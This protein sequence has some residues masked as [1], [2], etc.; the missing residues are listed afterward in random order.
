MRS[1][2]P[3]A[4]QRHRRNLNRRRAPLVESLEIRQ[5]LTAELVTAIGPILAHP[6]NPSQDTFDLSLHLADSAGTG[7]IAHFHTNMGDF[8]I[9][10][11]DAATPI[12]VAN[13]LHYITNGEFNRT[14]FSRSVPGFVEQLGGYN[15]NRLHQHIPVAAP[16]PSEFNS[17]NPVHN[18][19]GTVAMALSGSSNNT[20]QSEWFVSLADNSANLDKQNGGFTVFGS[21]VGDG[22]TVIDK[23]A[24]Q[25]V[26]DISKVTHNS[27]LTTV[28]LRGYPTGSPKPAPPI[29]FRNLIEV[30]SATAQ[31]GMTYTATSD[32]PHLVQPIISGR[33]ISFSYA[34]GA[35]GV[36]NVTV[37]G[38]SFDGTTVSTTFAVTVPTSSG[39]LVANLDTPGNVFLN[40]A[41][42][43]HPLS[44]DTDTS[45]AINPA[46][47]AIA[48]QPAH[49][50][51]TVDA[52]TGTINYTPTSGF[53]G[54][55]SF[56]Y[57]V[58]DLTGATS[59]AATVSFTVVAPP[60]HVTIGTAGAGSLTWTEPDGTVAHLSVT[61]GTA[62]VAFASASVTTTK[63]GGVVTATG[64][65]ATVSSITIT[66]AR[67]HAATLTITASGGADGLASIGTITDTG[68]VAAV[69]AAGANLTGSLTV[70]SLASLTLGATN[71]ALITIGGT[72]S[73]AV[74]IGNAIDTSIVAPQAR[75]TTVRAKE[76]LDTDGLADRIDAVSI[77]SLIINGPSAAR[78]DLASAG[79]SLGSATIGGALTTGQW[80]LAGSAGSITAKSA[81]AGWLL[82]SAGPVA[83]LR[84]NGDFAG[85]IAAHSSVANV[86]IRGNATGQFLAGSFGTVMITGDLTGNV[87]TNG[88]FNAKSLQLGRL[89][90][91]GNILN[92]QIVASGNIGSVTAKRL[93]GASIY[94]GVI[95]TVSQGSN[96]PATQADLTAA[97]SIGS[98][99]LAS[100]TDAVPA[101]S[102]ARIAAQTLGPLALGF[103]QDSIGGLVEGV[104]GLTLKALSGTLSATDK[105]LA[106][107]AKTLRDQATVNTFIADNHITLNDFKIV[108]VP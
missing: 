94:A 66:N 57:T 18:V 55:D 105:R 61:G 12:T 87:T 71:R 27:A 32:N 97:A 52:S 86:S 98:V 99:R 106:L 36:A 34:T 42:Q 8:D 101:F 51:A 60:V 93:A 13:F 77:G 89:S 11:T 9:A 21:V 30:I 48:T 41:A 108:I 15:I 3:R 53:T 25:A 84:V 95:S 103:I 54:P 73:L 90:V 58:R 10:L 91:G 39:G 69:N 24:A 100:G 38:R 78:L 75:L 79:M 29:Q 1:S 31:P 74:S 4:Q 14:I 92:D 83:S 16:I 45:A 81:A 50:T 68:A 67:N 49:G 47:V 76:Y 85:T 59:S 65:G 56:T 6:A 19:R 80:N 88:T 40:T 82:S 33:S 23:I 46:T 107:S 72:R 35:S 44:N 104:A 5:L 20:A 102:N 43:L 37:T 96:L 2:Q 64:A 22:M 7:T 63:A 26:G 70:G 17:A 62:D 28:P